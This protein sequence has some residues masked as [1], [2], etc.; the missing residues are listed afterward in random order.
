[1]YCRE[2]PTDVWSPRV[3]SALLRAP[4]ALLAERARS[5]TPTISWWQ[6]L[7][8][9]QWAWLQTTMHMPAPSLSLNAH[10][11][12]WNSPCRHRYVCSTC[13]TLIM[14]PVLSTLLLGACLYF[15][16][17]QRLGIELAHCKDGLGLLLNVI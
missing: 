5:Q 13:R 1:M 3:A 16:M 12:H 15:L 14:L 9:R 11:H 4:R 8:V 17:R 2:P 6:L 7:F 10:L